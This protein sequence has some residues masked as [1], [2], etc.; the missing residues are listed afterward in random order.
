ME[1]FLYVFSED[2]RDGL[3]ARGYTLLKSDEKN[4]VYVF[5]NQTEMS[6]CIADISFV[7]SDTLTF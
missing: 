1:K 4:E 5:A 3:L 6:F 2:D 7:R